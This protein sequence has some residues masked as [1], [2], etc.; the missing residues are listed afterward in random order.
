MRMEE[1]QTTLNF[2]ITEALQ[3][4]EQP[5]TIKKTKKNKLEFMQK[6]V[7]IA[8]LLPFVWVTLSYILAW[9]E[10]PT[11]LE[12]LSMAVVSVPIATIIS[13]ATQNCIRA[14]WFKDK[15]AT[16]KMKENEVN[17]RGV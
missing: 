4:V 5:K 6:A 8:L 10:K 15:T 17:N 12:Q 13:Y 16:I 7:L 11:T 2:V 1:K 9:C 3:E 14:K